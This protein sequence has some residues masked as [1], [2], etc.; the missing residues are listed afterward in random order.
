MRTIV[1]KVLAYVLSNSINLD[2]VKK[3]KRQEIRKLFKTKSERYLWK[4][5]RFVITKDP[6]ILQNIGPFY[7]FI[8]T[9]PTLL[10]FNLKN[11]QWVLIQINNIFKL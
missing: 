4:I 6:V 7:F 3:R 2:F 8:I 1:I 5:F 11:L 9:S 10:P